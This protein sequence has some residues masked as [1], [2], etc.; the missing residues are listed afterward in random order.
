MRSLYLPP[1]RLD[2]T[3]AG[4]LPRL[5]PAARLAR[6]VT[7]ALGEAGAPAPASV[8]LILTDDRELAGLNVEHMGHEGPTDVLSFPLLHPAAY[9]AHAG[10]DPEERAASVAAAA[11]AFG[12]PPGARP[13]L[14]DVVVS[15]ERAVAQAEEGRGGQSGT[16][17]WSAADELRLLVVH[18]TL[19]LCG[20]DHARAE[21]GE[22]M[23]ALE[24]RILDANR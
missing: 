20:W 8:G 6:L 24:R 21:E 3:V 7:H 18:G 13:H 17:Q 12:L 2:L 15:V 14:G 5:V 9:P 22:E 16:V 11:P 1:W 23:R 4:G 10:Q 19:H